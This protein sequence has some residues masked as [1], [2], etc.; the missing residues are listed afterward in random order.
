MGTMVHEQRILGKFEQNTEEALQSQL[1]FKT[2][3]DPI[4]ADTNS[5]KKGQTLKL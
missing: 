5:S 4:K 2:E 3:G 1:T